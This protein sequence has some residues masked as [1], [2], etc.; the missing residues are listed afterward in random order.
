MSLHEKKPDLQPV[1]KLPDFPHAGAPPLKPFWVAEQNP[2]TVLQPPPVS[3]CL[4]VSLP[5]QS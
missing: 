3:V 2:R 4:R 1:R 5:S